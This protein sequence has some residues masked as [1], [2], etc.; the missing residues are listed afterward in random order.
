[1]P[2]V[3]RKRYS[4]KKS[5]RRYRKRYT[6]RV[7]RSIGNPKQKIFYYTRFCD[8]GT[9]TSTSASTTYGA[10]A[11]NLTQVPG[12]TDFTALYDFYKIKAIKLSFV[13]WSNVTNGDSGTEH[14]Q[15][16]FTVI[17]YNDVGI[18]TAVTD[19]QQYKSCKWSPNNRIHKRY[20]KPKTIIDSYNE[21]A[22]VL[23]KQPWVPTTN[24]TNSYYGIKWA[25]ESQINLT[26]LYKIEAKFYL[27]FKSPI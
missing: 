11:F 22:L 4:K 6:R 20:F 12:Y 19:L 10:S 13:P 21:L 8:L 5:M 26:T 1:M 23:D 25:I 24:T 3:Y 9:I 7:P 2:R 15:R 18:P 17:D 27:A 14:F 16:I